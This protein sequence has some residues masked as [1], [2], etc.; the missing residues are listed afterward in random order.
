MFSYLASHRRRAWDKDLSV[1]YVWEWS[2]ETQVGKGRHERV[3]KVF[4]AK[5]G[6][7]FLGEIWGCCRRYTSYIP[8]LWGRELEYVY[9]HSC[10]ALKFCHFCPAVQ[11][12]CPRHTY[13]HTTEHKKQNK[14]PKQEMQMLETTTSVNEWTKTQWMSKPIL[15]V[16]G[17]DRVSGAGEVDKG[18]TKGK[19]RSRNLLKGPA[20]LHSG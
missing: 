2:Q 4:I 18:N 11:Q 12:S 14:T 9:T 19:E 8:L 5:Q 1:W 10:L 17:R 20:R 6:V 16:K 15:V 3:T 7:W 13:T